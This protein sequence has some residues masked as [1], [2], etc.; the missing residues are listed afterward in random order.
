MQI[1]SRVETAQHLPGQFDPVEGAVIGGKLRLVIERQ[2]FCGGST[3][4]DWL[5]PVE[6]L[7]T[8]WSS[9]SPH[10]SA[11]QEAFRI[12]MRD[13]LFVGRT[14]RKLIEK[15]ARPGH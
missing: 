5:R 9:R 15:T 4:R 8:A 6:C 12:A 2:L 11:Q 7:M 10:W 14:H 1:L 13:P 3:G